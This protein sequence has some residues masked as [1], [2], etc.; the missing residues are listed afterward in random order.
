MELSS[1]PK[2]LREQRSQLRAKSPLSRAPLNSGQRKAAFHGCLLFCSIRI[3]R[4]VQK[5][6]YKSK[7]L[8]R[9]ARKEIAK[10]AKKTYERSGLFGKT[11]E[12]GKILKRRERRERPQRTQRSRGCCFCRCCFW[13]YRAR[14]Q[15]CRKA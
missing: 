2:R 8:K 13:S 3:G 1:L 5:L 6:L 15:A 9:E 12:G 14:L 10:D 7:V 11:L 4:C